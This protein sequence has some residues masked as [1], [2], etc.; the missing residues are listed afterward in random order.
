MSRPSLKRDR[1]QS[2]L[3]L[4]ELADA[5]R[6]NELA[7]SCPD[8]TNVLCAPPWR[9]EAVLEREAYLRELSRRKAC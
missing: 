1:E 2:T 6:K 3:R 7:L 8:T 4:A 5:H 9:R